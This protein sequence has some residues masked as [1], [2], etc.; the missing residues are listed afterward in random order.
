MARQ[1]AKERMKKA[2]EAEE[3]E[4]EPEDETGRLLGPEEGD[5]DHSEDDSLKF[6]GRLFGGLV[7]DVKRKLPWFV[8]DFTD[9]LHI[10][11][12]A[13]I[14]YIYLGTLKLETSPSLG[15]WLLSRY[16]QFKDRDHERFFVPGL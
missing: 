8:S 15:Y 11:T 16:L 10:Q 4:E 13:S 5:Q 1:E 2:K 3:G 7:A 9:A 6:T 14:I 12:L